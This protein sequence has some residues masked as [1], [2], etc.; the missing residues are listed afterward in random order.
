M[1]FQCSIHLKDEPNKQ[2]FAVTGGCAYPEPPIFMPGF[3]TTLP[4]MWLI[5]TQQNQSDISLLKASTAHPVN[6]LY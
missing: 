4:D 3:I 1:S 2:S 6:V 5:Y